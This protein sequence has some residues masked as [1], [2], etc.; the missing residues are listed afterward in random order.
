LLLDR[1]VE[2][3]STLTPYGLYRTYRYLNVP[4]LNGSQVSGLDVH[5]Y[6][7]NAE[8]YNTGGFS[9]VSGQKAFGILSS[10]VFKHYEKLGQ[11]YYRTAVRAETTR[12]SSTYT[13]T[14]FRADIV[15][16]LGTLTAVRRQRN[17]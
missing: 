3:M 6:R 14:I 2:F 11:G 10:L 12:E 15:Y 7:N 17:H 8:G 5:E 16:I 1:T 4:L 13:R 9:T